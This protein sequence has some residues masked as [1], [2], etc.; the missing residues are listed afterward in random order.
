MKILWKRR[1][2]NK[3]KVLKKKTCVWASE[4]WEWEPRHH[5]PKIICRG[6]VIK[7]KA[8]NLFKLDWILLEYHVIFRGRRIDLS[9]YHFS[10]LNLRVWY[11]TWDSW[12]QKTLK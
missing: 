6:H 7:S 9:F 3:N 1:L 11:G 5:F 2:L 4:E 8:L 12:I 10:F